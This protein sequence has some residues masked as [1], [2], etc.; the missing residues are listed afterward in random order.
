V[1]KEL[2]REITNSERI[3][4]IIDILRLDGREI[5]LHLP[6]YIEIA[7]VSKTFTDTFILRLSSLVIN[8]KEEDLD[9][10]QISFI[11]S[12]VELFGKCRFIEQNANYLT[13]NYPPSLRS[14]K[15]R[16]YHRI[17][18]KTIFPAKIKYK[19]FAGSKTYDISSKDIPV[20]FSKI[21]W[22][23]QRE[24]IDIKKVFLL[25]GKEVKDNFQYSEIVL[26]NKN[27]IKS[28][29]ARVMRTIS[30]TLF[31]DDCSKL[32]SYTRFLPSDKI[33]NYSAYINQRK[34][35][36]IQ[37]KEIKEEMKDI[38][39]DDLSKGNTSKAIIP[40]LS[41]DGVIG[42]IKVYQKDSL[43]KIH[44]E[45]ISD[46]MYLSSLLTVAIKKS[47]FVPQIDNAIKSNLIDLSEGGL[48]LKLLNGDKNMVIPEDS[49]IQVSFFI[50]GSELTLKGSVCRK[51]SERGCYAI[52][53]NDIGSREK[54]TL[55][56]FI[57]ENI[58]K[59]K[60][61]I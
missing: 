27:N 50:K 41:E 44:Y 39:R 61:N 17:K 2:D 37:K 43:K 54:K 9:Y 14:R 4:R 47:N 8:V 38:I 49:K 21:Y 30:K 48:L 22:E 45:N 7:K 36:G 5:E 18:F 3:K 25:I 28:T 58:E 60:G 10:I 59:L 1:T 29:D 35:G 12:G 20:K 11:F 33:A 23:V 55:R 31:I 57:E 16:R 34:I 40:I 19:K 56:E 51:D 13:F 6:E 53:F 32:K 26:Y 46:L 42:H 24:S 52:M 15:K